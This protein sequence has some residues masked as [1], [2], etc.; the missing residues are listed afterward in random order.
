MS[1]GPI[2]AFTVTMTTG[3]TST[4]SIDLARAWKSVYLQIPSVTSNAIHYIKGSPDNSTFQRIY[5]P[6]PNTSSAQG[7]VFQIASSLTGV[8]VPIPNGFRYLKIETD[9]TVGSSTANTYVLI[10][11][12]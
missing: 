4:S 2:S 8:T 11:S 9:A 5:H 7:N 1:H 10:C 3:L 12:D 6:V